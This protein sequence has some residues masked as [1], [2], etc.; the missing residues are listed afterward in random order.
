MSKMSDIEFQ[1]DAALDELKNE[2]EV[3]RKVERASRSRFGNMNMILLAG[4]LFVLLSSPMAYDLTAPLAA[5]AGLELVSMDGTPN[6]VGVVAHGVVF[7]A[8]LYFAS[9]MF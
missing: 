9:K 8:V 6:M 1:I 5:K 7:V 2:S 3:D 4:L